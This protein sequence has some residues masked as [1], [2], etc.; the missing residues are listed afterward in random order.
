MLEESRE[1]EASVPIEP[2][3]KADSGSVALA[4][5]EEVSKAGFALEV[6][7]KACHSDQV[8]EA[9]PVSRPA[10]ERLG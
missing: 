8:E 3:P 5:L 4:G 9:Q 2:G 6:T 7:I 10:V 1:L